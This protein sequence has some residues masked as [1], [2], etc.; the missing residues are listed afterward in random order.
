VFDR[1]ARLQHDAKLAGVESPL[2]FSK[3][4]ARHG[5]WQIEVHPDDRTTE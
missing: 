1:V 5:Y 2:W 3:T 4:D